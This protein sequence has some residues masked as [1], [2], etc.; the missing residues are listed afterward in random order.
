[1]PSTLVEDPREATSDGVL[2]RN[3]EK[4]LCR[5][6]LIIRDG[7]NILARGSVLCS[8]GDEGQGE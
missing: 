7:L 4:E 6:T 3:P 8:T 5:T 2:G 1:M